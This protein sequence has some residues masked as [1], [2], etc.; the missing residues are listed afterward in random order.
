MLSWS[1]P[2]LQN[3]SAPAHTFPGDPAFTPRQ[4]REPLSPSK[5]S[6]ASFCSR[7][8]GQSGLVLAQRQ[9]D[10]HT[11][12]QKKVWRALSFLSAGY[13]AKQWGRVGS[14]PA[15]LFLLHPFFW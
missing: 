10:A 5:P 14:K 7:C 1:P 4:R 15:S 8:P 12:L 2:R 3:Q 13:W 11:L 9:R 6:Q